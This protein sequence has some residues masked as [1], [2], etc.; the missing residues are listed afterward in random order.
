M[1]EYL[2]REREKDRKRERELDGQTP[3]SGLKCCQ[4]QSDVP[5]NRITL[6]VS[7]HHIPASHYQ[8]HGSLWDDRE[9]SGF[10][11]FLWTLL[12]LP[13]MP[14]RKCWRERTDEVL[15]VPWRWCLWTGRAERRTQT[16]AVPKILCDQPEVNNCRFYHRQ[17]F[18]PSLQI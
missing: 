3:W 11:P 8:G 5:L 16:A 4:W 18:S 9:R 14:D 12:Q 2:W 6:K 13:V 10:P 15:L 7:C 1:C 17:T